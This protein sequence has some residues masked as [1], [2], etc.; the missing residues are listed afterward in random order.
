MIDFSI[1]N[2][3]LVNLMLII[4]LLAGVI[5]WYA[6]P[7]EMFPAVEQDKVRIST[8]FEGASPEE[9]ERQV[10]LPIEQELDGLADIDVVSSTS[11]EGSS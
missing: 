4:I 7:Q 3:L 10:T 11:S 2:P 1:R 5:S 8:I 6:M 9:M